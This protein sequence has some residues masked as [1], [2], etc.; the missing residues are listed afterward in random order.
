MMYSAYALLLPKLNSLVSM[1][2]VLPR[3]LVSLVSEGWSWWWDKLTENT[4]FGAVATLSAAALAFSCYLWAIKK[5]RRGLP[6]LPLG[7]LG[8]PL[9]GNLPFGEKN[10]FPFF[11]LFSV[12]SPLLNGYFIHPWSHFQCECFLHPKGNKKG[13]KRKRERDTSAPLLHSLYT[14]PQAECGWWSNT[15]LAI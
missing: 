8:Y 11:I 14:S 4:I 10:G 12:A 3:K 13:K 2:A 1:I 7:P 15:K 6:P 5:S 9:L